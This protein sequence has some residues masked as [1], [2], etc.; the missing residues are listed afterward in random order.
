MIKV[1]IF[2]ADGVLI[3]HKRR[4]SVT[5]AEKH[6]I[7]IE[8]TLPFFSGPFQDCLVGGED[9][10]ES[11][12]PHLNDWGWDKGVDAL[13]DYWFQLEHNVDNELVDYIQELRAEGIKCFLAT[14]N[15]KYRFQYI[16][17]K[18]GFQNMFDASYASAHLGHKKPNQEF[19]SKIFNELKNVDKKEVLFVDDSK[20]NIEGAENFGIHTIFYTSFQD[21]KQKFLILNPNLIQI[22]KISSV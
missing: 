4:F 16:L 2:D 6:G 21:F 19:F 20:E 1:I 7:S 15:E 11:I 3:P 17:D 10:K 13:L 22:Q 8:K 18:M 12:A 9:L 5:L 14:N